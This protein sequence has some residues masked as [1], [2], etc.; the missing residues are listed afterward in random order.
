MMLLG[1]SKILKTLGA[2]DVRHTS[3]EIRQIFASFPSFYQTLP[4]PL[5]NAAWAG[6]YQRE[7]YGDLDVSQELLQAGMQFH[8]EIAAI[9]EPERMVC[10]LG[11]G[12]S[13]VVSVEDPSRLNQAQA[14]AVT[15]DG[16]GIVAHSYDCLAKDGGGVPTYYANV[17]HGL[18]ANDEQVARAVLEILEQ[19]ETGIL[20]RKTG[21]ADR[22]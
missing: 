1:E 17:E 21:R 14:W 7:S 8:K 13:T 6:L 3:E 16:D 5:V 15:S 9:V 4:S 19:G 11:D 20:P 22:H 10:V 12:R 2:L 18:L